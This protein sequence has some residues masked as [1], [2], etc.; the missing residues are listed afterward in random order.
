[1]VWAAAATRLDSLTLDF[2]ATLVTSHSDKQDATPTYKRG[3]GFHPFG[4]WLDETAEP[5]AAMLR[6]GNAGANCS[7]DH[8]TLLAEAIEAL[9]VEYRSGHHVGDGAS[10]VAHPI[11]AR[12][13]SAGARASHDF[14]DA[15]VERNIAYSIGYAVDGR[16]RDALLLVQEEDWTKAVNA[17]GAGR[18]GAWVV[19]LSDLVDMSTW[20]EATRLVCRRERPHPDAQLS[21]FDIGQ[22]WRHTCFITDTALG[23]LAVLECRHRGHARVE[24][25]IRNWKDCG[26]ANLPFEDYVRNQA[27]VAT[28]MVAGCLL[29]WTQGT[30]LDGDLAKAEPKSL[31]YRLLHVAAPLVRRGHRVVMRLDK[32]WPWRHELDA[33]FVRLR[34]ALG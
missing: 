12:A 31:R 15:L 23:D 10:A 24:D 11:L 3:Y 5:L 13:D 6:P 7:A 27:W 14:V 2:D 4:V 22:D 9:P 32:T 29:A 16:V 1:M 20:P 8:V 34:A 25:R 30:C 33:A 17:D 26:L 19:E 28:S 18:D 21:L